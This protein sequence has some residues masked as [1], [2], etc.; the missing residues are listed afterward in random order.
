MFILM[1]TVLRNQEEDAIQVGQIS[2][3][4]VQHNLSKCV[5]LSC[6]SQISAAFLY[7]ARSHLTG[8]GRTWQDL[9]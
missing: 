7:N 2:P 8:T 6:F 1:H 3:H 5:L 9:S 4:T